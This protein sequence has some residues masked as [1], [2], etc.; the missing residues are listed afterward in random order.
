MRKKTKIVATISDLNCSVDF[1]KKLFDNG[2]NVV[3]INTA[4]ANF[5]GAKTIIENVRKVSEAIAILIDTKGPEIRTLPMENRIDVDYGDIIYMSGNTDLKPKKNTV[6]LSYPHFVNDV[7]VDTRIL[8]DDGF[9]ELLVVEKDKDFLKCKVLNKGYIKG[10]KSINIPSIHI[11]LPALSKKDIN[12]IHFAVEQKVDF[13]AHSFVRK[14]EDVIAV[15]TILDSLD[16]PIKII[17]KIENAEG[18]NNIKEILEYSYGV[19]VA[20]GDLAIEISQARIPIVQK[21]II[22]LA[23]QMCK[24]VIVAT[25]MLH[26]M[27]ENP[28]PTRAEVNDVANAIY[29]GTDAVMLS[30]ETASGKYPVESVQ[31]MT[32]IAK[33]IEANIHNCSS[34][35]FLDKMNQDSHLETNVSIVSELSNLAIQASKRLKTKA[36]IADTNYGSTI[37]NLVKHRGPNTIYAQCYN[38][39]IMRVLSLSY[40]V[41]VDYVEESKSHSDFIKKALR[42]ISHKSTF[43]PD[44][45]VVIVAGNFGSSVGATYIEIAKVE[46]LLK[47]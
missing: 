47:K 45:E 33:E 27:I 46:N 30:G 24:P 9:V 5:E 32:T 22:N 12:F 21:E 19:M 6:F 17:S 7:P 31:L 15:Q 35:L 41:Y 1:I 44:N 2:M 26:S 43:L 4:H 18:V 8:I 14:K 25:Q 11:K 16:S 28:R 13:I 38:K 29:D 36:I 10:K 20:R 37:L 40:G 23:T 3:R 42:N 39:H 34:S